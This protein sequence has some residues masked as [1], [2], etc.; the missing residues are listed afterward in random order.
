MRTTAKINYNAEEQRYSVTSE[1]FTNSDIAIEGDGETAIEAVEDFVSYI[2]DYIG[3]FSSPD[4]IHGLSPDYKKL[5]GIQLQIESNCTLPE[6][7][8]LYLAAM[9]IMLKRHYGQKDKGGHDYYFHP[10]RVSLN[11]YG[12]DEKIVALLHD[13]IEDTGM[14]TDELHRAGFSET[15]IEAILSVTRNEGESYAQ[16]IERAKQNYIGMVIKMEDLVDNMDIKRLSNLT[17][18]DLHRLNKYL[19]SWR[20]LIDLEKDTSM[21]KD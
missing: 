4:E 10:F 2:V 12:T 8:R 5:F 7:E 1:E 6:E 21:I 16:F 20:Y 17:E 19:H 3:D 11:R 18:K 14:T 9:N 13:T 15:I